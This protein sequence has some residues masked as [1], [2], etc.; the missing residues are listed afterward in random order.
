MFPN[1][2]LFPGPETPSMPLSTRQLNRALPYRLAE[3]AGIDKPVLSTAHSLRHAY[4][5]H[6]LERKVDIRCGPSVLLGHK[7]LNHHR[8]KSTLTSP[9][10]YPAS[11]S[12]Q[13]ARVSHSRARRSA[14]LTEPGPMPRP[15]VAG[16]GHPSA[17]H[18]PA[19][20]AKPIG[21]P[22]QHRATKGDVRHRALPHRQPLA[23]TSSAL[24]RVAS[25]PRS[26]YNSCRNRHCPKCQ[27][28]VC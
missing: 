14:R 21:T 24:R 7:K 10:R 1:G 19:F 13:S 4:A 6:L 28:A 20:R 15:V 11:R 12:G 9:P 8:L 5:T 27:G 22:Y 25:I 26:A 23:G 2:W 17:T 3:N 16:R 18:G